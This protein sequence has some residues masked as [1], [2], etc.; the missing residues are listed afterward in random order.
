MNQDPLHLVCVEPQFPGRL[1]AVA[2]WLVRKRGYRCR[3]IC[4][5][6]DPR[7]FWPESVGQ[8][9]EVLV[10]PVAA[11]PAV[12]WTRCLERGLGH[13]MTYYEALAK[14]PARPIDLVLGRSAGLGSTLFVPAYQQG[15]PIINLFDY[16]YHP[17]KYDLAEELTPQVPV[18]YQHWRRSASA[19]DLLDLENGISAWTPT[20]WQRSLFPAEYQGDFLV[21][22]DGIA[23]ERFRRASRAGWQVPRSIA[24][25]TLTPQARVVTFVARYL[26]QVRGFDRFLALADRLLRAR[27]DVVCVAIGNPVVQRGL[28][29]QFFNKDYRAHLLS[30]QKLADPGRVWFFDQARPSLVAEALAASDL[31][32]SPGRPYPVSRS[33][34]E[35]LAASCVVLA[36][37]IE[38]NREVLTHGQ[39]ALLLDPADPGAWE[40]QALAVLDDPT[41]FRP[42]SEA[43]AAL[44][45]ERYSHDV[46]L[47]RLA[48]HFTRLVNGER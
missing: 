35:A 22:H 6:A 44:V 43:A 19:M 37:D 30:R 31:H 46:C 17:R 39:T 21:Q 18:A 32:V 9:L 34:L 16:Y 2:D 48:E 42:L 45:R 40:Q 8:G 26:D 13:A 28:D 47:P 36:S 11:Q 10:C 20:H 38:P 23:A 4:S 12:E 5:G 41:A 3:F 29:V 25:R 7:E 1:G 33:L 15:I 24:G 14:Q 27:G